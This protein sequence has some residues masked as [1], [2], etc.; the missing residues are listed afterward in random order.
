MSA[1]MAVLKELWSLFVDDGRLALA[2]VIWVAVGGI[3][4]PLSLIPP[5]WDAPA[6]FVGCVIILV[7]NVMRSAGRKRPG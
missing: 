6:L 4:L 1:L 3:G 5:A 7:F 2:L